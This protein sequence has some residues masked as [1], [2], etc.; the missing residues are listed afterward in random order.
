MILVILDIE[1]LGELPHRFSRINSD[2]YGFVIKI[3][4]AIMHNYQAVIIMHFKYIFSM[5]LLHLG[6]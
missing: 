2:D 6:C 5:L 3:V 4:G 1:P